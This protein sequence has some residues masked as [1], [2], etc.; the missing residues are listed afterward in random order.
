MALARQEDAV[1]RALHV[2]EPL[3][4]IV[5][6]LAPHGVEDLVGVASDTFMRMMEGLDGD[7]E[8]E[9]AERRGAPGSEILAESDERGADLIVLGSH[10][11]GF[12]NRMLLG[13][14]SLHVLR[15]AHVATIVVPPA[16][17]SRDKRSAH[18]RLTARIRR[19]GSRVR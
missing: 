19:V 5:Q 3:P 13:S 12:F 11:L 6:D 7:V 8:L 10:G 17:V 1:I 4:T 16:A 15:H 18:S 2:H 14:T 9:V